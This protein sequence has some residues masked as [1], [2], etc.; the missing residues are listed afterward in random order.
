MDIFYQVL[1]VRNLGDMVVLAATALAVAIVFELAGWIAGLLF[2]KALVKQRPVRRDPRG[3]HLRYKRELAKVCRKYIRMLADLLGVVGVLAAIGVNSFLV[4]SLGIMAMVLIGSLIIGFGP[5]VAAAFSLLAR[6]IVFP[7]DRLR[8][9]EGEQT[10]VALGW[11][12]T[13]LR[14][15]SGDLKVLRTRDL[16]GFS[17]AD[18]EGPV[19]AATEAE[20]PD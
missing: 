18:A 3:A 2:E 10:L 19:E 15:D 16:A 13:L 12:H 4:G 1:H 17:V 11:T 6:S 20:A 7:G 14:T 8:F 9:A 5:D